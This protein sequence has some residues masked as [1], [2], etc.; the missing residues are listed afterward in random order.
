MSARKLDTQTILDAISVRGNETRLSLPPQAVRISR[1][2]VEFLSAR[3]VPCW[4]EMTLQLHSAK[5]GKKVNA[6][7][8]VVECTGN[9]QSGYSVAIMFTNLSPKAQQHLHLLA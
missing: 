5:D 2:G 8:V 1:N 9:R 7:G 4:K 3:P 6:T